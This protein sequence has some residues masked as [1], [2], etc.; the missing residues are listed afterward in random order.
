MC[1][2]KRST[3]GGL[4]FQQRN[5]HV[6]LKWFGISILEEITNVLY[7]DRCNFRLP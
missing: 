2:N 7:C 3:S 4:F 6:F 1:T 5:V